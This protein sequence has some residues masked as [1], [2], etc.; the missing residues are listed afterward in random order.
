MRIA[1]SSADNRG[2][3]GAVAYHFGRCPYFTFVDVDDGVIQSVDVVENPHFANHQPG[4]V[5]GFVHQQGADM[6]IAG[7]MGRRAIALFQ[8]LDIQAYTGAEENI[9][10]SLE[11]ALGGQLDVAEPCAGHGGAGHH[12]HEHEH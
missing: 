5:P 4:A 7:G 1:V 9:R 11:Q 3:D 12:D 10:R 2:L 6:I 8:E